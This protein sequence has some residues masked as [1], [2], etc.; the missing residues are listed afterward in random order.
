MS[1]AIT[2]SLERVEELRSSVLQ[3]VE[4]TR[5]FYSAANS[6]RIADATASIYDRVIRILREEQRRP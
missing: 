1:D 4:Q 3:S 2:R 5:G 6:V